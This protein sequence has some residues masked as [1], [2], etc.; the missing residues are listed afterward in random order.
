MAEGNE[1]LARMYGYHSAAHVV[2]KDLA[3]WLDR[4]EPD[5]L[6]ALR[7]LIRSGYQQSNIEVKERDRKGQIKV[8]S[9]SLI[10]IV[11]K[12]RL[13][14]VWGTQRDSTEQRRMED[15]LR[16]AQKMEA[17][18]RLAGGVAHDFNNLLTAM[19]G[20]AEMLLAGLGP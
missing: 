16:Q 17:I 5:N 4:T 20:S 1:A 3:E 19:L 2:G 10:G 15:Q 13:L 7:A 6:A 8:F 9:R 14:R 12:G 11:E 18:G